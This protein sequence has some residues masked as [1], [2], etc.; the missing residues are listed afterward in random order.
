MFAQWLK[1]SGL[2]NAILLFFFLWRNALV[3]EI[4]KLTGLLYTS[5][6]I[7]PGWVARE[8]GTSVLDC[9]LTDSEWTVHQEYDLEAWV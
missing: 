1:W 5:P 6:D 4:P 2:I 3:T 9:L 7:S 8:R